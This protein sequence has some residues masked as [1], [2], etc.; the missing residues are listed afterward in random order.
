MSFRLFGFDVEIRLSFWLFTA[1][2]GYQGTEPEAL[3]RLLLWFPV[4][5]LSILVHELGHAFAIRRYGLEPYIALHWMG[6]TTHWRELLPMS[7]KQHIIISLA[8]PFAGF[9]L[10][11]FVFGVMSLLTSL[12][13]QLPPHGHT[14][15][16]MLLF[17][18]LTWGVVNLAPVLPLD[19]GHVLEHALGP[20]RIRITLWISGI[21]GAALALWFM[22]MSTG[23]TRL[24]FWV[25]LF[26]SAALQSIVAARELGP[27]RATPPKRES[28]GDPDW[29]KDAETALAEGEF[30][31]A[32]EFASHA[33]AKE[34]QPT[35]RLAEALH[36]IAWA[37]LWS[38]SLR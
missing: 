7:R 35:R 36:V 4:V 22:K 20:K 37:H 30:D 19:G 11:G 18:N 10:G 27:A 5:L 8:G 25:Y 29:L 24:F 38:R 21:T 28:D 1:L 12:G 16:G 17:A 9:L 26:G 14:V 15:V 31:K 6:G 33:V 3:R 2:M 34:E 13:V 23:S 32:I